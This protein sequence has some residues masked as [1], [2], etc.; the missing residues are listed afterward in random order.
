MPSTSCPPSQNSS[1]ATDGTD[2]TEAVERGGADATR[3]GLDGRSTE[4]RRPRRQHDLGT[5]SAPGQVRRTVD[6]GRA[7][8]DDR[9]RRRRRIRRHEAHLDVR[10]GTA[11]TAASSATSTAARRPVGSVRTSARRRR[12]TRVVTGRGCGTSPRPAGRGWSPPS[13]TRSSLRGR[14]STA[15]A[16]PHS[17]SRPQKRL[18]T[19]SSCPPPGRARRRPPGARGRASLRTRR[20]HIVRP[21]RLGPQGCRVANGPQ[22][23]PPR[24]ARPSRSRR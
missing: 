8:L 12:R 22:L 24:R 9:V 17:P 4:Q 2:N 13:R 23:S 14:R 11:T 5:D 7:H 15:L 3:A 19:R 21:A 6:H 18:P 16:R 10:S 20:R 1:R